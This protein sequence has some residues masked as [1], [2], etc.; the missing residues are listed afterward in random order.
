MLHLLEQFICV[1]TS[2]FHTVQ[3]ARKYLLSENFIDL[4]MNDAWKLSPGH[5]YIL[6]PYDSMM[7]AFTLGADAGSSH[8]IRLAAAHGDF[9]GFRIKP[10][11]EMK[12]DGYVRLNVE[13]Y[14]GVNLMSWLDRPLS[15]AG[16]VALRSDDIWHPAMRLID[17]A[18]PILTIPNIAIHMERTMNQGLDL[19]KQSHM[20]PILGLDHEL[21]REDCFLELL[22][23]ELNV[24]S[25]DILDYE[26]MVY[27]TEDVAYLGLDNELFQAPRLDN[28]T[29]C[30]AVLEGL[31][32]SHRTQTAGIRIGIIF[33]HEEIGSG[34][35]QGADS[36]LTRMLFRRIFEN[37]GR[38]PE[39]FYRALSESLFLSA[40]V[41]HAIHPAY[42]KHYD[43]QHHCKP[44]NG[45]CIKQ[46]ASQSYAT[47][48]EAI[49]IVQQLC[50][51]AHIP[52]QKF[53]NHADERG[54]GTLGSIASTHL[55]VKTVD[56]GIPILSMHSARETMGVADFISFVDFLKEF[57][58]R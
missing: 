11:P 48:S 25:S 12:K 15:I 35:K 40:D 34:T 55:P 27:N 57:F 19:K 13:G 20:L 44:G 16:R 6:T 49:A 21:L 3:A 56:A 9:P 26:L 54:G 4:D 29:S 24:S 45:F 50:D 53:L 46:A 43:P 47:D 37:L 39:D 38:S 28:L 42:E 7:V 32:A 17:L 22:A 36:D 2:P 8:S 14:G 18:R 41:A 23:D 10:N 33:D 30:M 58:T 52:Y 1:S 31:I 5:S 51:R